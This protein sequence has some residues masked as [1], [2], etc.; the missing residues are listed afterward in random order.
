MHSFNADEAL[1]LRQAKASAVDV[2]L[3]RIKLPDALVETGLPV[4]GLDL[5]LEQAIGSL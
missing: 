5:C 1:I 3:D 2:F 4:H